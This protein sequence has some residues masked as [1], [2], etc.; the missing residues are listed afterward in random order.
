MNSINFKTGEYK[1]Y[2][3]NGKETIVLNISDF[4]IVDRILKLAND[5]TNIGERYPELNPYNVGEIDKEIRAMIDQALNCPGA[6]DKAFGTVNCMSKVDGQFLFMGFL[7]AVAS[8]LKK[9]MKQHK[10]ESEPVADD[11]VP[12]ELLDYELLD[13][14]R[15]QKYITQSVPEPQV[16]KETAI[17]L[18]TL[19]TAERERL[20]LELLKGETK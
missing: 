4:G 3:I 7:E 2:Q 12:Y 1:E 11:P 19:S 17:N 16:Q 6:S 14:E 5:M 18:A 9:D 13:N 8:Q 20:L 10:P 15:T